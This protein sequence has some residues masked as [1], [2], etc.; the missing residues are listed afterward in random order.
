MH[1]SLAKRGTALVAAALF[2][3]TACSE[4]DPEG[5]AIKLAADT[6]EVA[7]GAGSYVGDPWEQRA[8]AEHQK[9][10]LAPD[11]W[12]RQAIEQHKEQLARER[13]DRC[14]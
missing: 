1:T 7:A 12:E 3:L 5:E 11:G 6:E 13:E 8:K 14:N 10:M 4:S 2:V 9:E